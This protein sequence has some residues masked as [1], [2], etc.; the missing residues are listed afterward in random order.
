MDCKESLE[1]I[2]V[3]FAKKH[4]RKKEKGRVVKW[5]SLLRNSLLC[6][7]VPLKLQL[8]TEQML[9]NVKPA[10]PFFE[11][12][13]KNICNKGTVPLKWHRVL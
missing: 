3:Y 6:E 4:R 5:R 8:W 9:T 12:R 10:T 2:F 7:F 11:T 1:M 13:K